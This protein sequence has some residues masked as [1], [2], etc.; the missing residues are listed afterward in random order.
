MDSF[1]WVNHRLGVGGEG[2]FSVKTRITPGGTNPPSP[3][4]QAQEAFLSCIRRTVHG[5]QL[6]RG[7]KLSATEL[8]AD[9]GDGQL[10]KIEVS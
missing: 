9:E 4:A 5:Y 2:G 7:D 3:G 8:W 1:L 6:G 10:R